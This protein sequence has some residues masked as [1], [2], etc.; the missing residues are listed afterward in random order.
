MGIMLNLGKELI[1]EAVAKL[2]FC[3]KLKN[4]FQESKIIGV[5]KEQ[6]FN[7]DKKRLIM[8]H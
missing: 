4:Q 7:M 2:Q 6:W 8:Y 1:R 5:L 3:N